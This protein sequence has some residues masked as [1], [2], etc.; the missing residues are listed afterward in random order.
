MYARLRAPTAREL[1]LRI[2]ERSS[3]VEFVDMSL[4]GEPPPPC[5]LSSH[6]VE[7]RRQNLWN[8]E[9]LVSTH[10]TD[11]QIPEIIVSTH[12]KTLVSTD[13]TDKQ[14]GGSQNLCTPTPFHRSLSSE[15]VETSWFVDGVPRRWCFA[16]F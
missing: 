12:S 15:S 6:S 8:N 7:V 11:K 9:F 4:V 3:W 5:C 10:S 14:Q 2:D 16:G 13:S 1:V